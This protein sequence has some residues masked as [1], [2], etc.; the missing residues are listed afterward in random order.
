MYQNTNPVHRWGE[1]NINCPFYESCLDYA[2]DRFWEYWDCRDCAY[3]FNHKAP[4]DIEFT[5]EE[6]TSHSIPN[7][8][9]RSIAQVE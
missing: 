8:V 9:F 2:A 1:K 3:K 5:I 6:F 4:S 7:S